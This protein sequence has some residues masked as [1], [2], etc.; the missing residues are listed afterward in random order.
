M[1]LK[2][3]MSILN[4]EMTNFNELYIIVAVI[5]SDI[6]VHRDIRPIADIGTDV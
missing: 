4:K 2:L 6:L 3:L 1:A 5:I